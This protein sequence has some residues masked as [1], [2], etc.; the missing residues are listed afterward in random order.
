MSKKNHERAREY[1]EEMEEVQELNQIYWLTV[2]IVYL[3]VS[4]LTSAWHITWIIWLIASLIDYIWI[5][6]QHKKIRQKLHAEHAAEYQTERTESKSSADAASKE[7]AE[8]KQAVETA[9]HDEQPAKSDKQAKSE[10]PDS[11]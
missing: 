1:S 11:K 5:Y 3:L 8:S 4:F 9:S 7:P 10:Q 6:L 2:T